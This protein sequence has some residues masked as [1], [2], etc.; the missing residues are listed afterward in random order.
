MGLTA[1]FSPVIGLIWFFDS[2]SLGICHNNSWVI[3]LTTVEN[4]G[5]V[6]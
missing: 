2:S 5:A 3:K 1:G 6:F 4:H